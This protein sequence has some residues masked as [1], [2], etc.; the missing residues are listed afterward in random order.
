MERFDK[1]FPIAYSPLFTGLLTGYFSFI[2]L[3]GMIVV[4][5]ASTRAWLV[6]LV[7]SGLGVVLQF[8]T[9]RVYAIRIYDTIAYVLAAVAGA[10]L[11]CDVLLLAWGESSAVFAGVLIAAM[12]VSFG[13]ITYIRDRRNPKRARLPCAA[14]G[15]MDP[16]TGLIVDPRYMDKTPE[17]EQ[18]G[19]SAL[20]A[21][22]SL[23]PLI[24]GLSM[25]MV[26]GLPDDAAMMLFLF[27]GIFLPCS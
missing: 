11:T 18:Q 19:N 8:T 13:A 5:P 14:T 15:K 16:K 24:A 6:V 1:W 4:S 22:L 21:I 25:M 3:C 12:L 7:G 10:A 9:R 27:P 23:S 26:R 20:R 17:G 2:A